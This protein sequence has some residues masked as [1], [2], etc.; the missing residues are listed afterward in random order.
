MGVFRGI[1]SYLV[2]IFPFC[3]C[4]LLGTVVSVMIHLKFYDREKY[5]VLRELR[6]IDPHEKEINNKIEKGVTRT[7]S[8]IAL[9]MAILFVYY[10]FVAKISNSYLFVILAVLSGY[11]STKEKE[12]KSM[13]HFLEKYDLNIQYEE[14]EKQ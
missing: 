13:Q 6:W 2:L 4:L 14:L 9:C 3:V 8:I 5:K 7:S 1:W 11:V 10:S 12:D